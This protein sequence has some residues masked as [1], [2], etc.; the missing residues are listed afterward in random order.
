M[1]ERIRTFLRLE[2]LFKQASYHLPRE[3]EWD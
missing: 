1:N 3:S 2:Y